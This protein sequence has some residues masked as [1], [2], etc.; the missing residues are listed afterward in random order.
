MRSSR[1]VFSKRMGRDS[2]KTNETLLQRNQ[3]KPDLLEKL[4][5]VNAYL[6][7]DFERDVD[8]EESI[9]DAIAEAEASVR[10]A[11]KKEKEASR[12]G[13]HV[14]GLLPSTT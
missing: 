14:G 11:L 3:P 4:A 12:S 2:K 6:D 5:R 10:R 9:G 1:S 7:G 8:E 13:T